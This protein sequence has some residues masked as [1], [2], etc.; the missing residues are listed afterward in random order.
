MV[1]L[2]AH[3]AGHPAGFWKICEDETADQGGEL[4]H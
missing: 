1:K 2:R 3:R 4:I